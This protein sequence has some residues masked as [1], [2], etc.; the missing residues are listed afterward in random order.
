[1]TMT[2]RGVPVSFE[3]LA[4]RQDLTR[5]TWFLLSEGPLAMMMQLPPGQSF[6]TGGHCL[7]FWPKGLWPT[8]FQVQLQRNDL[9]R[10]GAL[11]PSR[12]L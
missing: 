3:V 7:P 1:M 5:S 11:R 12:N 8:H 4:C 6:G 10:F 2:A 9:I